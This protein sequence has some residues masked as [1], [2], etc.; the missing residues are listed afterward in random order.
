MLFAIIT[1]LQKCEDK[2]HTHI[3]FSANETRIEAVG[4]LRCKDGLYSRVRSL[5]RETK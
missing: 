4:A 5:L 3:L 2:F 1:K